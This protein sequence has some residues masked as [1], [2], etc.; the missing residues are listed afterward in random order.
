MSFTCRREE[1][2]LGQGSAQVGKILPNDETGYLQHGT[3]YQSVILKRR[4]FIPRMTN[5]AVTQKC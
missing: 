3:S 1:E 2:D 4:L 5:G